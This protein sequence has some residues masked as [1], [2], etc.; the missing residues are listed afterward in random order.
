MGEGAKGVSSDIHCLA[1][2]LFP[3]GT[4]FRFG[5]ALIRIGMF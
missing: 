2:S 4:H 1:L 5:D 3:F